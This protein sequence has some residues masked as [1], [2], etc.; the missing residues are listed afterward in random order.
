MEDAPSTDAIDLTA[1][2]ESI[3][4]LHAVLSNNLHTFQRQKLG[5]RCLNCH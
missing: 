5:M 4:F 1:F 3:L 2:Y